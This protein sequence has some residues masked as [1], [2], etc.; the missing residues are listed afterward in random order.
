M[1]LC[2]RQVP[3]QICYKV[4]LILYPPIYDGACSNFKIPSYIPN[5]I[6]ALGTVLRRCGVRPPYMATMPSSFQISL[7]HWTRPVY[8]GWPFSVGA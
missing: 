7:K 6:A 3:S 1:L 2:K 4:A 5:M 8:L